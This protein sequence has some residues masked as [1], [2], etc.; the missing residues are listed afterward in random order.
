MWVDWCSFGGQ[1]LLGSYLFFVFYGLMF[2]WRHTIL[3]CLLSLECFFEVSRLKCFLFVCSRRTCVLLRAFLIC[4]W[5]TCEGYV[6]MVD[7]KSCICSGLSVLFV[8]HLSAC[9][10]FIWSVITFGLHMWYPAAMSSSRFCGS[11]MN[12][13]PFWQ[14]LFSSFMHFMGH[15]EAACDLGEVSFLV[16]N[17][18]MCIFEV[19]LSSAQST[20]W[21]LW[22]IWVCWL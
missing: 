5:V 13:H 6:T 8:S 3:W 16:C 12:L 11:L 10:P 14:L 9:L 15:E 7:W 22:Y 19:Q 21:G 2:C 1:S 4:L 18:C 20:Y 17:L